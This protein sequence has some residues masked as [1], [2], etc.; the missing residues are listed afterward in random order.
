MGGYFDEDGHVSTSTYQKKDRKNKSTIIIT[1]FTS[2]S[3]KFLEGLWKILKK[4]KIVEGGTLY[5]T[6]GY[7]L[8]FSIHDSLRLYNFMY[9]KEKSLYL[10]GKK[11]IFERYFNVLGV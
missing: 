3:K 6:R 4:Y 10:A 5:Y 2:G 8:C 11:V 7:R 1:G 9:R